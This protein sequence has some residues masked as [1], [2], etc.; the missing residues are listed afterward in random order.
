MT[1]GDFKVYARLLESLDMQADLEKLPND[2]LVE[3]LLDAFPDS[4]GPHAAI[5]HEVCARLDPN[6]GKS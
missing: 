1:S 2:K 3:I 5:I 6:W 4:H